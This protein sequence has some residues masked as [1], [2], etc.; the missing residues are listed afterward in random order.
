MQRSDREYLQA[1]RRKLDLEIAKLQREES[2]N[3]QRTGKLVAQTLIAAVALYV[4][5]LQILVPLSEIE[6][7]RAV[8][9]FQSLN[10]DLANESATLLATADSLTEVKALLTSQISDLR[11]QVVVLEGVLDGVHSQLAMS[12]RRADSL[13]HTVAVYQG[14]SVVQL[15]KGWNFVPYALPY[16][17]S[18]RDA[19]SGV[20]G[21]IMAIRDELGRAYMLDGEINDLDSL[22]GGM[23]Y[24]VFSLSDIVWNLAL[25]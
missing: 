14:M 18:V 6:K 8:R 17:R 3:L 20:D 22:H 9:D 24:Q 15:R 12:E 13:T 19:L 1:K 16:A 10:R 21:Q 23:A 4:F 5:W 11:N 25:E 2:W 7:V